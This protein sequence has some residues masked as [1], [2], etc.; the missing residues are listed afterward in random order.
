[1]LWLKDFEELE[2][3][4]KAKTAVEIDDGGKDVS[5]N[6][7]GQN[8]QEQTEVGK[9]KAHAA[10]GRLKEVGADELK[11]DQKLDE[12]GKAN[13]EGD[14]AEDLPGK[15]TRDIDRERDEIEDGIIGEVH[16]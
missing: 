2:E 8:Y 4:E 7:A 1:V 9:G 13:V 5:G 11:K 16:S 14:G 6:E 12:V 15:E 10:E 3:M